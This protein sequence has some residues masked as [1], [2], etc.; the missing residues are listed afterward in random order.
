MKAVSPVSVLVAMSCYQA[1]KVLTQG[2][3]SEYPT[4]RRTACCA[5]MQNPSSEQAEGNITARV[6]CAAPGPAPPRVWWQH[7][8]AR[9]ASASACSCPSRQSSAECGTSEQ[10]FV[11][12]FKQTHRSRG[13]SGLKRRAA[14][15]NQCLMFLQVDLQSLHTS[16]A[17]T[18][19]GA[20]SP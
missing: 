13:S 7:Q 15:K 4:N 11:A 12:K 1:A 5:N 2:R 6:F 8:S 17:G 10:G 14:Q 3:T 19:A 9:P 16:C 18:C 20:L